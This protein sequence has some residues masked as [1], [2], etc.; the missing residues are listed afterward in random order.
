M[1]IRIEHLSKTYPAPFSFFG[2]RTPVAA[3]SDV[4]LTIGVG[5]FGLLGPNGAGKTTLM[6]ILCTLLEPTSGRIQVGAVDRLKDPQRVRRM[7]GYLPQ[8]FG[9][10]K[11][12]T[13]REYLEFAASMKG[14]SPRQIPTLLEK[15]NLAHETRK[16]V[17]TYSGGMKRRLGIAQALLGDPRV[18]VVD[19]P[20]AG[21]DPEERL[22]FRNLLAELSGERIVL[23]STHI[24]ADVESA[25]SQVA[26][27]DRGRVRFAGS[28]AL[29]VQRAQGQV[30]Q[31]NVDD[32]EYSRLQY[33]LQVISSRRTEQGVSLRVLAR[34][35]PLGRGTPA[36]VT[37]EDA[38]LHLMEPAREVPA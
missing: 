25:C 27:I 12:L 5:M 18:L 11:R 22:R 4:T 14:V 35:N 19:E 24:V 30:W 17:G 34:E 8:E 26:V 23:L 33:Q 10:F 3:L 21:L 28:P 36:A 6:R 7:I 32:A 29:L 15:V 31:L 38:Y 16:Y 1:Q 37:M 20:T 9:F 2:G 13:A